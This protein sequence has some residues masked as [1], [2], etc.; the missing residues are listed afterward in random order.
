MNGRHSQLAYRVSLSFS[1]VSPSSV[2]PEL[3]RKLDKSA[4]THLVE[5]L[6]GVLVHGTV[7]RIISDVD[8]GKITAEEAVDAMREVPVQGMEDTQWRVHHLGEVALGG[9]GSGKVDFGMSEMFNLLAPNTAKQNGVEPSG[10]RPS[11]TPTTT[12]TTTAQEVSVISADLTSPHQLPQE[13]L[14]AGTLPYNNTTTAKA[15]ISNSSDAPRL[16]SP[17]S[18]DNPPESALSRGDTAAPPARTLSPLEFVHPLPP[19]P[20]KEPQQHDSSLPRHDAQ[21]YIEAIQ[22]GP[23]ATSVLKADRVDSTMP[24]DAKISPVPDLDQVMQDQGPV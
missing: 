15:T 10:S 5:I 2:N 1:N 12:T 20:P 17:M 7:A 18:Q 4:K 13:A 14:P 23:Q 24:S 11:P 19:V 9:F 8:R 3:E 21:Q 16:P 22:L 6:N